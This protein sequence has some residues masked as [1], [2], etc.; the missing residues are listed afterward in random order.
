[1]RV[2]SAATLLLLCAAPLWL[3]GAPGSG[4]DEVPAQVDVFTAGAEGYHTFRIPALVVTKQGTLLAFCEGRK[5]GRGDHGDIDLVLKRST[6]G[7]KTWGPLQ[8]VYEEGNDARIT[9][10]N[11]CPVLDRDTGVVWLPFTRDNKDVFVTSSSD[12]GRTWT[13]PVKI[14]DAVKK[15][16]WTWYATGPGVGIQLARGEHRGRLVIPCD[17]KAPEG[18]K[19][20]TYSHTVYSDDHGKTWRLGGTVAPHTNECQAAELADGSLLINMR[21]YWGKDGGEPARG[22]MR[23]SAVSKDGGLTW[24]EVRFDKALPE[25]VCQASLHGY[26]WADTHGKNRLLFANPASATKRER[27]TVRLSHDGGATWPAARVLEE[28]PAAYSCLADL[29]DGTLACL[30]ERGT[31]DSY[32]K[33]TCARFS[34]AW[35]TEGKDR[36]AGR[37]AVVGHRGMLGH[38]PENTLAGF[39]ACFE[40]RVGAELDVR[41]TKDGKLAVLHDATVDRTTDG[42]GKL[43]DLTLTEAQKLDAGSRFDPSF[44]GEGIPALADVFALLA[45]HPDAGP[46]AMDLKE[47]GTEEDVVRLAREH[48]VL[49]R[50]VFIGLA[51]SNGAVRGRLRKADPKAHVARLALSPEEIDAALKDGDADWLY[52]RRVPSRAEVDRIHAAGKRVFLVGPPF[53]GLEVGNWRQ[54]AD[55]GADAILTDYPLDL[56]A[57][58]RSRAK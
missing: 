57:L 28:G 41:R 50:L 7:G 56:K 14:T 47:E 54:A 34:L 21:N 25:P 32:E 36:L 53:A 43:A 5:T 48:G 3:A 1:M 11:P 24:G 58:L 20:L 15:P 40:L 45:K 49:D 39:R 44:K 35:L 22:N 46:V 29:P 23:T 19:L 51:I 38:A 12:D 55:A 27:M 42:K 2:A 10:G 52:I 17:H 9:I 6:D 30:Y 13:R 37:P 16:E 33:V 26:T 8:L 18:G 31:K 4:A